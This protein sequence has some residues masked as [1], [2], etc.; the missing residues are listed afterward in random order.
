MLDCEDWYHAP[1]CFLSHRTLTFCF[2]PCHWCERVMILYSIGWGV[3]HG[4]WSVSPLLPYCTWTP[5]R[6]HSM[7]ASCACI[8][9]HFLAV[10]HQW[11]TAAPRCLQDK[12]AV[13]KQSKQSHLT[14]AVCQWCDLQTGFLVISLAILCQAQET[15]SALPDKKVCVCLL[16][17]VVVVVDGVGG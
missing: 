2:L 10:L 1:T 6:Q 8:F 17:V 11:Y 16:L 5:G 13:V 12:I 14:A 9:F 3:T 7:D 15:L 4:R